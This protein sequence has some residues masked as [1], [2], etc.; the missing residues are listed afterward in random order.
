MFKKFHDLLQKWL[1]AEKVLPILESLSL[2]GL[3]EREDNPDIQS[4]WTN[5]LAAV[6][7][8]EYSRLF[9]LDQNLLDALTKKL[10]TFSGFSIERRIRK[11]IEHSTLRFLPIMEQDSLVESISRFDYQ[12]V[13]WIDGYWHNA[14]V[15]DHLSALKKIRDAYEFKDNWSCASFL[16]QCGYRYPSAKNA[17]RAWLGWSGGNPAGDGYISWWDSLNKLYPNLSDLCRVDYMWNFVFSKETVLSLPT[18]CSNQSSCRI[19]PLSE[20]CEH[21]N[22][23]LGK[24]SLPALE[25]Y[26]RIGDLQSIGRN[27]LI[28]YLAGERWYNTVKQQSLLEDFPGLTEHISTGL[29]KESIDDKFLL[30]LLGLRKLSENA[31]HDDVDDSNG[32][33]FTSSKEIYDY[34]RPRLRIDQQ[35]SFYTL[36]IDNKHRVLLFKLITTG[37]LNQSLVHPREVFAPAIQLRAAAVVL[38]HNHPSGDPKPSHQDIEVTGR[39]AEVGKLVGIKVLDHIVFGKNGHYSFVDENL[40]PET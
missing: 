40:M 25:N 33:S 15:V 9:H 2:L 17:F 3:Q 23:G 36:I 5:Y 14:I 18:L 12:K 31:I 28:V 11:L 39:M 29:E 4:L 27:D 38:I 8:N 32:L 35:E 21:Y 37:T 20:D 30:F 34:Y 13:K 24:K 26:I 10:L 22:T 6:L 16:S 19:C 7:P 1:N